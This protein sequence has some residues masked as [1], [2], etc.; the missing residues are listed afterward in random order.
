MNKTI[1]VKIGGS[2]LGSHDTPLEDIVKLQQEGKPVV[3][4][5]GGGKVITDWLQRQGVETTFVRGERVTDKSTLEVATAVLS[6][7]VNKDIVAAL[8]KLGGSAV[9]ISGVDGSLFEGI[10]KEPEKGYVGSVVKVNTTLLGTLLDGDFVPVVAPIGLDSGEIKPD[11]PI[12]LNYNADIIAGEIAAAIQAERLIFLTDVEGIADKSGKLIERL[13]PAEA[14]T[15]IASGVASGGMIPKI[16]A[17][18]TALSSTPSA[19]IIDGRQSHAL[20][21]EIEQSGGGT[22][23]Q[24]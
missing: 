9:G 4:V 1:V 22:T 3:V 23:I 2:T 11:E 12:T 10:I 15:L 21:S 17:C 16:N 19:C 13:N 18:L 24:N 6:G 8:N 5:H 20:L 14:E 7:L